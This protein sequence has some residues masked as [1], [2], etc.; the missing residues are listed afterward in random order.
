MIDVKG[1]LP[2]ILL[3]FPGLSPDEFLPWI[4]EGHG[5]QT[6]AEIAGAAAERWRNGLAGW[7][8]GTAEIRALREGI[9]PRV[10]TPGTQAGEPLHLLS[11]FEQPS[12]LWQADPEAARELLRAAVSLLLR[13]IGRDP[14][15]TRCRDHVV[16]SVF[17]ERRLRAGKPADVATLLADVQNPPIEV[18]GAM[19][20]DEFL[21]AKDRLSLA[22]TLNTL[23][24]SPTFGHGGWAFD[25]AEW[26]RPREDRRTPAVIVSVA[27]LDEDER[28]LVLGIVLEQVLAW[29]RGQTGTRHLRALV[30]FD[31]VYG[32][33]PPHPKNPPTKRPL[34]SLMKQARGYGVGMVLATQNPMDLDYRTLSNAGIWCAGR[35]STDAD[36]QRVVEAMASASDTPDAIGAAELADVL[37]RLAS[38][39]FVL[40]NV[41]REPPLALMQSRMTL[42][43][44]RGPMTRGDLRRLH[45]G[46]P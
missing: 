21:P 8:L 40:R 17:A 34:V 4:P 37:K 12:P 3:T 16:L 23:L 38:R 15:P 18:L 42:S 14:D 27:H 5:G 45:A 13:L 30:V 35:L 22:T 31:E 46:R 32:F 28:H 44:L 24:A 25:V 41:H 33:I 19:P 9:A 36:R 29:T 1:D 7:G 43:W 6:P 10:F 39:W 11:A 2:N 20:M 26:L